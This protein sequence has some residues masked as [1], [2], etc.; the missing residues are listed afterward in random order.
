MARLCSHMRAYPCDKC[1]EEEKE[2]LR[3]SL[4]KAEGERESLRKE[5]RAMSDSEFSLKKELSTLR[6]KI[7]VE[8]I[9]KK[10][11]SIYNEHHREGLT[12]FG[13]Y[14]EWVDIARALVAHLEGK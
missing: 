9:A 6:G 14:C 3:A 4:E 5:Y 1:H 10:L 11:M 8:G 7:N 12:A 2:R 13:R